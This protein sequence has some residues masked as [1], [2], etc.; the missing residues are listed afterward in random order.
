MIGMIRPSLKFMLRH[1]Y[2]RFKKQLENPRR[3]QESL[4][5]VLIASLAATEYG[6]SLGVKKDD[7]YEAF[8]RK[9][10]VAGYDQI[11]DWI[12]KQK[13]REGN[14]IV[15]EPVLFYEKSSGS[16]GPQKYI[17]YTSRLKASF[18]R[19]FSIWLYDL[20]EHGPLFETAK[21]FISISP[22]FGEGQATARGVKVGLDDDSDYLSSGLRRLL[23]RF[24]VAP[25]SI[26]ELSD[27]SDFK[28]VLSALL[29]AEPELEIISIWNPSL[30]EVILD[31]I[32]SHGDDLIDDL[33]SGFI[34]CAGGTFKFKQSP[35]SRVAL[36][37]AQPIDWSQLWPRL[38]LISCW[39]SAGAVEPR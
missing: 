36:L 37:K 10:P 20:L 6:R 1:S 28:R 22:A 33:K 8:S 38:K 29:V 5:K 21:T 30:L 12:E 25:A 16:S 13:S 14:V 11:S 9:A 34:T 4:L 3:A 7:D 23:K 39:T 31:Y 19:M 2:V 24:L 26:K 27:P 35:D 32:Q 17:P 18:N 15:S